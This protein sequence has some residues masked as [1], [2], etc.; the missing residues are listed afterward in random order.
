MRAEM[1]PHWAGGYLGIPFVPHGRTEDGLDCWG[2]VQKILME[3]FEIFLPS[4]DNTY[5]ELSIKSNAVAVSEAILTLP[6]VLTETPIEGDI[7]LLTLTG[8]PAHVGVYCIVDKIPMVLH[9]DPLGRCGSRLSRISD[10]NIASRIE[11]YY[12]VI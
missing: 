6:L 4:L 2:L 5:H 1:T 12:H 10:P 11:G 3:Q 9:A 8:I 7:V